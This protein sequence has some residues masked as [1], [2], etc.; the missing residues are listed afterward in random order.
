MKLGALERTPT[1]QNTISSPRDLGVSRP[2]QH[3]LSPLADGEEGEEAVEEFDIPEDAYGA[4]TLAIVRDFQEAALGSGVC[5]NMMT[6]LSSLML[7]VVNLTLQF[8]I[9][10]FLHLYVVSPKVNMVQ[11]LY[12]DYHAEVF[13]QHGQFQRVKW[14]KFDRQL[15][16]CQIA[17]T[18]EG[19]Y[20]TSLFLW[21]TSM[22]KELRT[23]WR[24][25][26]NISSVPG[27]ARGPDMLKVSH[28]DGDTFGDAVE[29][30]AAQVHIVALTAYV[31]WCLYLF[32]VLPKLII[33]LALLWLG[34]Q[35]L[36][37]TN[38]FE[39]LIMNA[40]AMTF[41]THID[42]ML[43][44]VLLPGKYR[45]E[46]AAINFV[47]PAARGTPREVRNREIARGFMRS[48]VYLGIIIVGIVSYSQLLQD[49]LPHDVADL[50]ENCAKFMRDAK[51]ICSETLWHRVQSIVTTGRYT[52]TCYPYGLGPGG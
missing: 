20:I 27:C 47:I 9:T 49:V 8:M 6:G 12:R 1:V 29:V 33:C 19:F 40:V 25:F 36:S 24:L 35:W 7:N 4:A 52:Q 17:V 14:K 39:D 45:E 22:M 23:T 46:V 21:W 13:D 48:G 18:N 50:R 30:K 51:P 31:R 15:E 3:L 28:S 44:D 16:I 34:S 32:V 42:E 11:T 43:Y 37:A 41:V 2:R 5:L 26:V 10:V 38:Q